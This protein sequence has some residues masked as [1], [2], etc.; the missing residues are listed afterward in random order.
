MSKP[1][2]PFLP[3]LPP[4]VPVPPMTSASI[5]NL[6]TSHKLT[7]KI[8]AL[9]EL[10]NSARVL[11][12]RLFFTTQC[13]EQPMETR[14]AFHQWI[15]STQIMIDTLLMLIQE[16]KRALSQLQMLPNGIILNEQHITSNLNGGA[17]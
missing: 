1:N 2:D 16:A 6:A 13:I 9:E 15:T 5:L 3:P 14:L 10:L 8:I 7:Y 12:S 4:Q 17:L 11:Q